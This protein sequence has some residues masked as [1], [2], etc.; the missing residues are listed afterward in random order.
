MR[1]AGGPPRG[2]PS[3]WLPLES[4]EDR[5]ARGGADAIEFEVHCVWEASEGWVRQTEAI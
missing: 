1:I 3:S 2:A 4:E 5:S